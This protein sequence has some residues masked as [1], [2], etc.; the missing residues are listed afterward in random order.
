MLAAKIEGADGKTLRDTVDQL[1]N[2]LGSAAIVLMAVDGGKVSVVAG[3]SKDYCK[4]IPAG[5]LVNY[6]AEQVGGR[7][8]GRADLAQAGGNKPEKVDHA[9]GSVVPWVKSQLSS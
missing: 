2:K 7:G 8:G 9:I 1:K 3:V 6:V 4:Q 5:Q